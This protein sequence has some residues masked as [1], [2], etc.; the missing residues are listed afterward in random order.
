[1]AER[2]TTRERL[3]KRLIGVAMVAASLSLTACSETKTTPDVVQT[4]RGNN[5]GLHIDQRFYSDGYAYFSIKD[6][7]SGI[8]SIVSTYL[9]CEGQQGDLV[10]INPRN[11]QFAR[12]PNYPACADGKLTQDEFPVM[13]PV[14][15]STSLPG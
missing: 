7:D 3:S 6:G 10:T 4:D 2:T 5:D 14:T 11:G 1:M 13:Q 15:T 9:Y 8:G 12:T